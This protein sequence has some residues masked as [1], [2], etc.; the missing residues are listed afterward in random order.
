M[1]DIY[2]NILSNLKILFIWSNCV[3]LQVKNVYIQSL[4]QFQEEPEI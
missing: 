3:Q 1:L 2:S 4:F